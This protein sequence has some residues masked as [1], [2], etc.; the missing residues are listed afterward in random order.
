M[1]LPASADG[2]LRA[3]DGADVDLGTG[4]TAPMGDTSDAR[5][6]RASSVAR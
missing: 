2:R 4:V 3:V 6:L 1:I 5:L